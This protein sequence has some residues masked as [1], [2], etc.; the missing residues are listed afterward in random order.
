MQFQNVIDALRSAALASLLLVAGPA[1]GT[2]HDD[3]ISMPR[4]NGCWEVPLQQQPGW[5]ISGS[6]ANDGSTLLVVDAYK[7]EVLSYSAR[8][9]FKGVIPLALQASF[10]N[11]TPS[12]L[13]GQGSNLFLELAQARFVRLDSNLKPVQTY[14]L[15][16]GA[17]RS[18]ES[19]KGIF[20]WELAGNDAVIFGDIY[21]PGLEG[22]KQWR[23][24]FFRI[25]L[26]NP[27]SF[28]SLYET[29][30]TDP[31]RIFYRLGTPLIASIGD[32]SYIL[33]MEERP[34]IYRN[35]SGESRLEPLEAFPVGFEERPILPSW[36]KFDDYAW[37]M[38]VVE[39]SAMPVALFGWEGYLY[40]VGRQPVQGTTRWTLTKIDPQADRVVWTRDVSLSPSTH[41]VTVVPGPRQ[42]AWIQKGVVRGLFNQDA[43]RVL[44]IPAE[45]LRRTV[46]EHLCQ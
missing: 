14:N 24:G 17:Q 13:K 16:Q 21:R 38:R 18:G 5:T 3:P 9:D 7:N 27:S 46:G 36:K 15:F 11:Y 35:R 43:G 1:W 45:K 23:S 33:V 8:G 29:A 2:Q 42:W 20:Q 10:G 12:T 4:S 40:I 22:E 25:P 32:V 39:R 44:F 31:S 26:D 28:Q 6:W 30:P 34:R 41:H 19:I 37:L